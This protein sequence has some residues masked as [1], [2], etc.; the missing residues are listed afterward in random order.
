VWA[1]R[2]VRTPVPRLQAIALPAL[3]GYKPRPRLRLDFLRSSATSKL[4]MPY[5]PICNALYCIGRQHRRGYDSLELLGI[6]RSPVLYLM[7]SSGLIRSCTISH[8]LHD[9]SD[10]VLRRPSTAPPSC[11][12]ATASGLAALPGNPA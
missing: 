12:G 11:V 9:L 2:Y 5:R 1:A 6:Q 8:D 7:K 10:S 4:L 3:Q